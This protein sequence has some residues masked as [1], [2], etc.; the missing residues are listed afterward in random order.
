MPVLKGHKF[1]SAPSIKAK[2]TKRRNQSIL[3]SGGVITTKICTL[4]CVEKPLSDFSRNKKGYLKSA[5]KKCQAEIVAK[6]RKQYPEKIKKTKAWAVRESRY[7]RYGIT[8]TIFLSMLASQNNRCAICQSD[9]PN[10]AWNSWHIDHDHSCCNGEGS[11]GK[12]VRGI[13]C[14]LCNRGL[15]S[16]LDNP[17]SLTRAAAYIEEF[18]EKSCYSVTPAISGSNIGNA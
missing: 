7:K 18:N 3:D 1:G 12:C 17:K 13:L 16:F 4:C 2:E 8:K 15:G 11:C 10:N 5:C 9:K 14:A 6:Y